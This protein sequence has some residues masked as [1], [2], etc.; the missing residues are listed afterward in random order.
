MTDLDWRKHPSEN[1]KQIQS[2]QQEQENYGIKLL[3]FNNKPDCKWPKLK[4]KD[5]DWMNGLK[6]RPLFCVCVY[7]KYMLVTT[8]N[9]GLYIMLK[10]SVQQKDVNIA[11]KKKRTI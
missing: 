6:T 1:T 9:E 2:K 10:I 8:V 3:P 5:T 4:S 7:K 11:N